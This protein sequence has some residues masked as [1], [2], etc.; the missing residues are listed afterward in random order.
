MS[1]LSFERKQLLYARELLGWVRI[2]ASYVQVGYTTTTFFLL[3]NLK[4]LLLSSLTFQLLRTKG[5]VTRY[6]Y[7]KS[8]ASS[9]RQMIKV[10]V[11]RKFFLFFGI[12]RFVEFTT[13]PLLLYSTKREIGFSKQI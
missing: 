9:A 1:F 7:R 10:D 13:Q 5:S 3:D 12:Y 11:I 2:L 6:F 8:G 4:K